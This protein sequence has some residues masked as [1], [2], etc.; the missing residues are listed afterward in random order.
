MKPE[1][2]FVRILP[3]LILMLGLVLVRILVSYMK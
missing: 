2:G 3:F 1:I